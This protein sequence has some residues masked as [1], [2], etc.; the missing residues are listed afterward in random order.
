MKYFSVSEALVYLNKTFPGIAPKNE[1]TIRRAIRNGELPA[2]QRLGRGG[3]SILDVDLYE[4][5]KKYM[6]KAVSD[7]VRTERIIQSA[8]PA[9]IPAAAQ[10]I[11]VAD[12]LQ[13]HLDAPG[14][15]GEAK[16]IDLLNARIQWTMR[17]NDALQH[18]QSLQNEVSQCE[19]EIRL[20]DGELKKIT[21]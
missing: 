19:T 21:R 10:S 9:A 15:G 8:D 6:K 11:F 4:Y 20:I 14:K 16:K 17:K 1:E 13:K 7:T 2:E 5:S 3:S 18:I 12:I